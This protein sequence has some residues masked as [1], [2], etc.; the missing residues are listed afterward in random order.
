M[1]VPPSVAVFKPTPE[2]FFGQAYCS[3]TYG[4]NGSL[5]INTLFS[6]WNQVMKNWKME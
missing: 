3:Q 5:P 6:G 1:I 2:F 4:H